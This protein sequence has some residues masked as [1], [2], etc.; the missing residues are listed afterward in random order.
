MESKINNWEKQFDNEKLDD[1]GNVEFSLEEWEPEGII[2]EFEPDEEL[3]M[4]LDLDEDM[5]IEFELEPV[6]H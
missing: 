3:Q 2:V 1:D 4:E 6:L 5:V